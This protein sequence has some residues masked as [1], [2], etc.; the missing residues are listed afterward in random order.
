[1][2]HTLITPDAPAVP[3][4]Q[5]AAEVATARRYADA[6]RAAS[7]RDL[8]RRDIARF[9][10]WCRARGLE[11]LPATPA[12]VA[13]YLASL[14]EAGLQPPTLTGRMA[15]IAWAHRQAGH[16]PP[17]KRDDA[18]PL[19][20]VMSGIRRSRTTP[21]KKARAAE[22]DILARMLDVLPPDSL[23]ATRDRAI[24]AVGM[25]AALRRSEIVA[26]A[27]ED[28]AFRPEGLLLRIRAS[29]TDQAGEGAVVA[30]PH[31]RAIRPVEL[32]RAWL[33]AAGI[34]SGP[35]FRSFA[36]SG[37]V[38]ETAMCDRDVSRLVSRTAAAAGLP[39]GFSGHSLRA[40]FITSAARQGVTVFRIREV[41]RHKSMQVLAGYVREAEAFRDH[42]GSGFL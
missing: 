8:Y 21:V 10:A 23:R 6:S 29:K 28:L 42:A 12:V 11:A 35:V 2:R 26:L 13:T 38:R 15:A 27:V 36:K 7:T 34:E 19:L 40:G 41:S 18:A 37:R 9:A 14:A 4:P 22:A 31:G 20:E 24:L 5:V 39:A 32:L 16:V 1:M 25:A 30:I 3:V 17:Q 33:E